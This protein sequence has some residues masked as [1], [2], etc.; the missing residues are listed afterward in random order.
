MK[1][2]LPKHDIRTW[3]CNCNLDFWI[4][5]YCVLD[6]RSSYLYIR[7]KNIF[8]P[9]ASL[10]IK[11]I[12]HLKNFD[13][14]STSLCQCTCTYIWRTPVYCPLVSV[15]VL[16]HTFGRISVNYP[17]VYANVLVHESKNF[18]APHI[19]LCEC[20]CTCIWRIFVYYALVSANLT[21]NVFEE[22]LCSTH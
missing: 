8:A 1:S 9:F 20:T 13:V 14:L 2:S 18:C 19:S 12:K 10:E 4:G 7:L 11:S 16:V 3:H 22:P 15:N 17:L 6:K 5:T 21:V